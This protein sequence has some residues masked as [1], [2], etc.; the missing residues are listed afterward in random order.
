MPRA[1]TET[2]C[3]TLPGSDVTQVAGGPKLLRQDPSAWPRDDNPKLEMTMYRLRRD[4]SVDARRQWSAVELR[5]RTADQSAGRWTVGDRAIT[6]HHLATK[7]GG[8]YRVTLRNTV[9]G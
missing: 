2:G 6:E 3:G 8:P 5:C 1:A 7:H 4:G 9:P